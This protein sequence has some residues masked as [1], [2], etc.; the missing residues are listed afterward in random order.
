MPPDSLVSLRNVSRLYGEKLI[1]RNID[2]DLLPGRAY[3]L[4]GAN[5]AGKSTLLRLIAGIAQ[6]DSGQIKRRERTNTAYLGHSTFL[7]P[8]LTAFQNLRF[9]AKAWKHPA[10]NGEIMQAL[11]QTGLSSHAHEKAGVF[12][13]GMAQRLNFARCLLP[14]PELLLLDE[15][16]SGMDAGTQE[17]LRPELARRRSA[18]ACIVLVS[19]MPEAD[20]SLADEIFTIAGRRLESKAPAGPRC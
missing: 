3:L 8:A 7:Y 18:G 15:P 6:P 14:E 13:R 9:W 20:G 10:S 12:S 17:L 19:H 11:E 16:F 4:L 2:L 1:F 5:G